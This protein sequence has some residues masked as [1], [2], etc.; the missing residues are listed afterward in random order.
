MCNQCYG[1]EVINEFWVNHSKK[2]VS[3][4]WIYCPTCYPESGGFFEC[5]WDYK[6]CELIDITEYNLFVNKGYKIIDLSVI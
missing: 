5:P 1:N 4:D 2:E 6:E 3:S